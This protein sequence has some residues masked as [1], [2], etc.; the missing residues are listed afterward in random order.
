MDSIITSYSYHT[1]YLSGTTDHP[2]AY[3]G[4]SDT[5]P[6]PVSGPT[7]TREKLYD[8]SFKYSVGGFYCSV[9]YIYHDLNKFI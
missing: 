7:V 5:I 1:S 9:S 4:H 2:T 6:Y 3:L 8:G